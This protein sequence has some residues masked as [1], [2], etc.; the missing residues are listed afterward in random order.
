MFSILSSSSVGS[1]GAVTAPSRVT[2]G[3]E[4]RDLAQSSFKPVVQ[5]AESAA[6]SFRPEDSSQF[7]DYP[8]EDQRLTVQRLLRERAGV[9]ADESVFSSRQSNSID[10]DQAAEIRQI[11]LSGR[12]ISD[13]LS[14]ISAQ[15]RYVRDDGALEIEENVSSAVA[16]LSLSDRAELRAEQRSEA[17][18]EKSARRERQEIMALVAERSIRLNQLLVE[19]A[20]SRDELDVGDIISQHV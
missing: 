9:F 3:L 6:T 8:S 5:L 16:P 10:S 2:V 7:R 19:L 18:K 12:R 11:A 20:M 1:L 4:D 17:E 14:Q 15:A 13:V